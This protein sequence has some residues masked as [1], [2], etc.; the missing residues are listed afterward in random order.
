M[1]KVGEICI[2]ERSFIHWISKWP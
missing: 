2:K 1:Q